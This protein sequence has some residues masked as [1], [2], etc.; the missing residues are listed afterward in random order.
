MKNTSALA[1]G[2]LLLLMSSAVSAQQ[3]TCNV[4]CVRPSGQIVVT[5]NASS[6]SDAAGIIDKQSDR[7]CQQAGHGA[8]TSSSMSASQCSRR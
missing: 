7:V 8:S 3:Y 1:L 2:G 6:A 4:H 5:V